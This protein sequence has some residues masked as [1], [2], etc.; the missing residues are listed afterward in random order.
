ML[1]KSGNVLVTLADEKLDT[2]NAFSSKVPPTAKEQ[3]HF[4]IR[5]TKAR[6]DERRVPGVFNGA[7]QYSGLEYLHLEQVPVLP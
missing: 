2:G 6:L 3:T 4:H 5:A 7:R 1:I